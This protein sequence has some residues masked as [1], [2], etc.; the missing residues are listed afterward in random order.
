[1]DLFEPIRELPYSAS[2]F[3]HVLPIAIPAVFGLIVL[4]L[5]I[6]LKRGRGKLTYRQLHREMRSFLLG[7]YRQVPQLEGRKANLDRDVFQPYPVGKLR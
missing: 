2:E 7:K 4:I 5:D 3:L 6:Y 1:M